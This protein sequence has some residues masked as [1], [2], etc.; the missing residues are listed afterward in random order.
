VAGIRDHDML[1]VG[2]QALDQRPVLRLDVAGALARDEQGRAEV[3]RTLGRRRKADELVHVGGERL[4]IDPPDEAGVGLD[5][6]LQEEIAQHGIGDRS[7][8]LQ[9]RIGAPLQRREI[10]PAHRLDEPAE[11]VCVG[12]RRDVDHE[13]LLDQLGAGQREAHRDLAAET[14]AEQRD[15]AEAAS[16]DERRDVA[17]HVI[18]AHRLGPG[19]A[20]VVAQ[21]QREHAMRR[22]Q[23]P[24]NAGPV[25]RRAEQAVEDDDGRPG[26]AEL[27][28]GELDAH[29]RCGRDASRSHPDNG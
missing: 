20:A 13:Q 25:A 17:R 4:E 15:R 16:L 27:V 6:V 28:R 9:V 5:Q 11:G 8:Q 21:I 7:L 24:A 12:D 18:E 22:G 10:D 2:E 1:S 29:V 3:G 23:L 14:V 19:R 26:R